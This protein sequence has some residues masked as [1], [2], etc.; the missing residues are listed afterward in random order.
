[1][2]ENDF[3]LGSSSSQLSPIAFKDQKQDLPV[4]FSDPNSQQLMTSRLSFIAI[5][6]LN[7]LRTLTSKVHVTL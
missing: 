7:S 1:M 4:T 5:V 3:A 2:P 6:E